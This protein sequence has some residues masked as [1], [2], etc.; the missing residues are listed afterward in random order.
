MLNFYDG[1]KHRCITGAMI[2]PLSHYEDLEQTVYGQIFPI[3][4]LLAVLANLAVAAVLSQRHMV[5]PTN[6]VLRYMA[7]AELLVGLI[8]LPWTIFFFTM[9]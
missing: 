8:P 4:V 6:V 5:T 2:L 3:I 9:G 7:I 1:C